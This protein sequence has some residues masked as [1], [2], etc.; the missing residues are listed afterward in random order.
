MSMAAWL[1]SNEEPTMS[2][3]ADLDAFR[4]VRAVCVNAH[5]RICAGRPVMA[6]PTATLST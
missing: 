3:T 1:R 6:I 2:L 4:S 5:V